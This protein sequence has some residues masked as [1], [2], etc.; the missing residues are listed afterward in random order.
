MDETESAEVVTA[1]QRLREAREAKGMSLEEIAAQTRIPTRH[2]ASLEVGDWDK[3]PAATYSIGFAKNFASAVGLDRNEIGDQLR[4]EMGGSRPV[5]A[6]PEVYEAADPARTMPK[7]LVFGTLGLLVLVV[8][9]LMWVSNRSLEEDPVPEPA[10]LEAPVETPV[11][12]AQP[13]QPAA[14][15][16]VVLTATDA[17]WLEIKD[18][19]T[20]LKQGM[21]ERGQSFEIPATATAPVLT[22][23]KPEALSI[24]V[25]SQ[26]APAVGQPGRTVS[27]VSL[28]AADLMQAATGATSAP[29][30]GNS[31]QPNVQPAAPPRAPRRV[32]PPPAAGQSVEPAAPAGADAPVANPAPAGETATQP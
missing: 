18:G 21:M 27:G 4:S 25:G 22:T 2:L 17:V 8:L 20:V 19:S 31:A 9:A 7:G 29:A 14:A 24:A 15:G 13:A 16:P 3:L 1:G 10:N 12:T 11:A 32:A 26:Q 5:F 30:T 6:V 28:K 23:G